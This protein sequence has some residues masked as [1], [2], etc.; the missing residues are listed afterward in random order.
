MSMR[1]PLARAGPSRPGVY[2][3]HSLIRLPFPFAPMWFH[4]K[5][6][7]GATIVG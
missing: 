1:G 2:E 5:R 7:G 4:V 3:D 6:G